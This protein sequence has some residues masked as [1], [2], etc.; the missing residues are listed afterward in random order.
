M[1]RAKGGKRQPRYFYLK[2]KAAER[3]CRLLEIRSEPPRAK[4]ELE[5]NV[6]TQIAKIESLR[7]EM[8]LEIFAIHI[9]VWSNLY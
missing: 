7:E 2:D 4:I 9:K 5:D 3:L 6:K 1:I 8:D